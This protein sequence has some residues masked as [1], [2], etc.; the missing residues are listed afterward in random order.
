MG[1]FD[2]EFQ[3]KIVDEKDKFL[4]NLSFTSNWIASKYTEFL[5]PFD[6]SIQHSAYTERSQRLACYELSKRAYGE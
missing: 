3:G 5:K 6:L 4:V 2:K 1:S